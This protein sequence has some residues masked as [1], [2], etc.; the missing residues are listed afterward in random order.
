MVDPCA[1][2]LSFLP[3]R[4]VR[5]GERRLVPVLAANGYGPGS[6]VAVAPL[7]KGRVVH[8]RHP[9]IP[10]TRGRLS[11]LHGEA[12]VNGRTSI[13]AFPAFKRLE[14]TDRQEV[15]GLTRGFPPYSDFNF[16]SL[17]CWDTHGLGEISRLNRNLVVQHKDYGTDEVFLSF[18]GTR[19][20]ADTAAS[21]L[22]FAQRRGLPSRLRLVPE[23]VAA[24]EELRNRFAVDEDPGS[25][26]YVL[27]TE[28]WVELRGGRFRNKRN[29]IHAFERRYAPEFRVL[30]LRSRRVQRELVQLFLLWSEKRQRQGLG[31]TR[32]E[33][34]ALR[35]VFLL[36]EDEGLV[37]FGVYEA[38]AMRGFS[39]NG[40]LDGGYAIGHFW[41]ADHELKGIYSYLLHRTCRYLVER[42]YRLFNIEQD[43]GKSG[44]AYSKHLYRPYHYLR[45]YT[46]TSRTDRAKAEASAQRST[47]PDGGPG[48]RRI[49]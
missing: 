44:L 17:W 31:E 20:V 19:A 1:P 7:E 49:S 48:H 46:V 3:Y 39:V 14:L 5:C 8:D 24:D 4:R 38:G 26:D 16:V 35:R 27:S 32:N 29:A 10:L 43:L 42:G 18:L 23:V 36:G 25:F 13:P 40:M 47:G 2:S 37:G 9:Q 15:E 22:S 21:L 45:K 11:R 33:L 41:K 6:C 12:G 28:E 30:D 34:M